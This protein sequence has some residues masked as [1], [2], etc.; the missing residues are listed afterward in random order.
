AGR[1]PA[2]PLPRPLGPGCAGRGRPPALPGGGRGLVQPGH[3][4]EPP[5]ARADHGAVGPYRPLSRDAGAPEPPAPKCARG[6]DHAG[7]LC[8]A[9]GGNPGGGDGAVST[10]LVTGAR[11]PIA[12]DLARSFEAAGHTVHLADSIRPWGAR[13]T[14][15]AGGRL[16][17]LPPPRF[18][19]EA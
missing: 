6:A 17:G 3:P 16:H 8:R 9:G 10:I 4:G 1:R 7:A 15:A 18:A 14:G 11:A 19:F 2:R 12:L 5:P 13:F